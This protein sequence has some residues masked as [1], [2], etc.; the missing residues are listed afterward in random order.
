MIASGCQPFP[1]EIRQ[2]HLKSSDEL[3][4]RLWLVVQLKLGEDNV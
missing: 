1:F 2:L 3:R 4:M